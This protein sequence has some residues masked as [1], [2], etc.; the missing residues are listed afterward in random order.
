MGYKGL[1]ELLEAGRRPRNRAYH[2]VPRDFGR[3]RVPYGVGSVGR[4]DGGTTLSEAREKTGRTIRRFIRSR[5]RGAQALLVKSA[6]GAGKTTAVANALRDD[7][8]DARILVGTTRLAREL[9]RENPHYRLIEGR[10]R[11]NCGRYDIVKEL[12]DRGYPVERFACIVGGEPLCPLFEYCLYY[13]QFEQPG[14][15]VAATEQLFNSHYL[16]TGELI[17]LDDADLPRALVE[18]HELDGA[19]LAASAEQLQSL[20]ASERDAVQTALRLVEHALID[21]PEQSLLGAAAWD[22]LA[23]VAHRNGYDLP[24]VVE[25]LPKPGVLPSPTADEA[26]LTV[27][28]IERVPPAG[29][30][31]LLAALKAELAAFL[32]GEDFNSW[33]KITRDRITVATLRQHTR[34]RKGVVYAAELP[35]L[36]LDATPVRSL[37]DHVTRSHTRLLDV[38]API[39]LPENVRV[40]QYATQTNGY[41]QM[42][43]EHNVA[44]LVAQIQRDRQS[45]PVA[46]PEDE[47]VVCYKRTSAAIVGAGFAPDRVLTY[48]ALRG[49]NALQDVTQLYVVGRPFPAPDDLVYLAQ[50]IH[51]GEGAISEQLVLTP[52]AYGGQAVAVDVVDYED[53]RVSELLHARREDELVQVIHR[54]R[55]HTLATQSSI[56]GNE[57][58]MGV[59]LVLLTSQPIPGLRVD[60]LHLPEGDGMDLNDQRKREAAERIRRARQ[61]LVDEGSALTIRGISARAGSNR[62]TVRKVL[63]DALGNMVQTPKGGEPETQLP[64]SGA[65]GLGTPVHTLTDKTDKGVNHVPQADRIAAAQPA[66][67][68]VVRTEAFRRCPACNSR[69]ARPEHL[70]FRCEPDAYRAGRMS[71]EEA[72]TSVATWQAVREWAA[73]NQAADDRCVCEGC[74]ACGGHIGRPCGQAGLS[75][76]GRTARRCTWCLEQTQE[77]VA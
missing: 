62:Q 29:V 19:T 57:G 35:M 52:L 15:W 63:D 25:R 67:V 73:S 6:A 14:T 42:A 13:A 69:P 8:C 27:E 72:A 34:S 71:A 38:E 31:K 24:D 45:H 41:L 10:N 60:E 76:I 51:H 64:G 22:H 70:C 11:Q 43:D 37:V 66:F 40:V 5:G 48:G 2:R 39:S 17:V 75:S 44:R 74:R 32:A 56:G 7:P 28:A 68:V 65:Q 1:D 30:G 16:E 58:R 61:E 53:P 54:A 26:Y 21:A 36:I 9:V 49:T 77:G 18:R 59:R 50:V 46:R 23:A 55:L 12:G 47:A 33:L 20:K 4:V 3:R